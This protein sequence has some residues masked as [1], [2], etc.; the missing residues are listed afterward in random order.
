[1]AL[2]LTAELQGSTVNIGSH[3]RGSLGC[4]G[5]GRSPHKPATHPLYRSRLSPLKVCEGDRSQA[6]E[7][8]FC[9]ARRRGADARCSL[10]SS[11]W[12]HKRQIWTCWK[13]VGWTAKGEK[14]DGDGDDDDDA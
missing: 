8:Y 3:L 4:G 12:L 11:A 2:L 13:F 1:M 14:N 9:S 5:T 7:P 6:G 10:K